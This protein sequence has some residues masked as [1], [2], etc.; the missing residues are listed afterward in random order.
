MD[1][2]CILL[3]EDEPL[4]REMLASELR[5]SGFTVIEA[6]SGQEA[7]AQIAAHT[8][9]D[10]LLTDILL[11]RGP[12]GWDVAVAF[13]E[14][15]PGRP[16]I[17]TSAFVPGEHRRVPA[18]IFFD[19]PY[20]PSQVVHTARMLLTGRLAAAPATSPDLPALLPQAPAAV[21]ISMAATQ[22]EGLGPDEPA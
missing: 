6:A 4:V 5:D 2:P 7:L 12:D 16:V 18:S 3:A 22:R 1:Q 21:P 10:L 9:I 14:A 19:K 13:R 17:Y 11:G 20:L 8:G 15:A